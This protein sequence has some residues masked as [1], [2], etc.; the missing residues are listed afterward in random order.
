MNDMAAGIV[1]IAETSAHVSEAAREASDQAEQGAAVVEQAVRQMGSIGEG[2]TRAAE[3]IERLN[4]RS[5]EIEGIL[6]TIS[7]LT[8]QINLLALNASIEA[9]RA[10]EHGRGFAV[11]AGEVKNLAHQSEESAAKI[12]AL[13]GEIQQDTR[14]AVEVMNTGNREAQEGISMIEEVRDIFAHILESSRNVAAHIL[15]VSAASEEMSAGSEQVSASVDE[16]YNIAKLASED[17][18]KVVEATAE[19]LQA[20]QDIA[21][22]VE[23]LNT[24]T[25]ELQQ[26]VGKFTL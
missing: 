7:Q 18:Q 4:S 13:I 14:H 26:G 12:A 21:R 2:T 10:G 23:Q 25:E 5:K 11:V 1:K 8:S 17:A 9:A 15:E 3:A 22:S 24:V 6:D 20:I 19:Q 16:M